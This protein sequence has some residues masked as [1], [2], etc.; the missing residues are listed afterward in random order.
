MTVFHSEGT[1]NG[2]FASLRRILRVA[3]LLSL[4]PVFFCKPVTAAT[5]AWALDQQHCKAIFAV[6]HYGLAPVTGWLNKVYG[7]VKFDPK[8]LRKATVKAFIESNSINSGSGPRDFHLRSEHFLDV[9]KYPLITF[10]STEVKPLS[11]NRFQL[12]GTLSIK[13]VKKKVTLDCTGPIGPI[14]DEKKQK[15]FG[16]SGKTTINRKDFG[17][18]WNREASPGLFMVGDQIDIILEIELLQ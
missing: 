17:I 18:S 13:D 3:V 8:D 10:D 5:E 9:K 4:I 14:T 2:K 16:F 6:K 11:K 15:R 7:T 12:T 1:T